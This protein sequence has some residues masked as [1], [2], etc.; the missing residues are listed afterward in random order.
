MVGNAVWSRDE[1][2]IFV[3]WLGWFV[4]GARGA[5]RLERLANNRDVAANAEY[6]IRKLTLLP[7][8]PLP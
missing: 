5:A 1:L 3:V 2:I 8:N 6:V 7:N 4:A